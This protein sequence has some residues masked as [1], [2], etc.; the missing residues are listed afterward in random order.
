MGR[1]RIKPKKKD[2]NSIT[3]I[4]QISKGDYVVHQNYGI[5]VYQGIQSVTMQGITKDY[6]LIQYQGK[7]SLYVPVTQLD[8]ISRY[9]YSK[10][11]EKVTLSKLGSDT[12]N[13][14]KRKA[15]KATE[16]MAKELIELYAKREHS[17]GYAFRSG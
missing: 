6:L 10:D 15:K 11:D 8:L 5:G 17:K 3:S 12:W 7:D 16:E 9:T 2:K 13:K 14:Q 4:D 1:Q